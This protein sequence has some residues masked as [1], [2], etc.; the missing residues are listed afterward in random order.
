MLHASSSDRL[1]RSFVQHIHAQPEEVFPLLC[2]EREKEWLPGWTARMICSVSGFAERGAVFETRNGLGPTWWIVTEYDSPRRIAF[3]RW[4]PDGLVVHIEIT[5]ACH[6]ESG[7]AVCISYTSTAVSETGVAAL[8]AMRPEDWL[9]NMSFWQ[10]SMN[11]WLAKR[12]PC[13]A[14]AD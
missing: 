2:P 3:A 9:N 5:L 6:H 14:A 12:R 13:A 4:Q 11:E 1:V 7:T 8:A 10:R